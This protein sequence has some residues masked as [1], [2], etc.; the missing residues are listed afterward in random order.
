MRVESSTTCGMKDLG[1]RCDVGKVEFKPRDL[2]NDRGYRVFLI[3]VFA[4]IWICGCS[5]KSD[6]ERAASAPQPVASDSSA[7]A[8]VPDTTKPEPPAGSP[9]NSAPT[10]TTVPSTAPQDVRPSGPIQFTD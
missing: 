6:V 3:F 5:S 9:A 10:S 4:M 7:A 8:K 2:G 1:L